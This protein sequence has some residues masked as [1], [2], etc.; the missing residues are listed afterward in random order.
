MCIRDR[1]QTVQ[2]LRDRYERDTDRD[3]QDQGTGDLKIRG[4]FHEKKLCPLDPWAGV[5]FH[6]GYLLGEFISV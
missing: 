4:D 2:V 6:V 3:D 1:I 5:M